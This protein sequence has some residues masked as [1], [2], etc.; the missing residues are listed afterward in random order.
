MFSPGPYDLAIKIAHFFWRFL[1]AFSIQ[2]L[3][4][5]LGVHNVMAMVWGLGSGLISHMYARSP[6]CCFPHLQI[7]MGMPPP[8]AAG[9]CAGLLLG[10]C[11]VINIAVAHQDGAC[12]VELWIL[13]IICLG[14]LPSVVNRI[15]WWHSQA[16]RTPACHCAA[17][18]TIAPSTN[19]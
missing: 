16:L 1:R 9:G 14:A 19:F 13:L 2:N 10:W 12:T 17:P 11:L 15:Q 3:D 4:V 5:G 18:R 8:G 6:N 7:P